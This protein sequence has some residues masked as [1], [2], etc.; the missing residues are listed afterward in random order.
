MVPQPLSEQQTG[1][2]WISLRFDDGTAMMGYLMRQTDAPPYS[3][4]T[5]IEPDGTA[6]ALPVG[7]LKAEPLER[8]EVAGREV[9]TTWRLAQPARGLD[10]E[11]RAL[12]PRA[13]NATAF[14]YWEGPVTVAGSHVGRGYLEM[15]GL[16]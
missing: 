12:H 10:I 11:V 15:T 14:E 8:T 16:D 3:V 13:W 6:T 1:W 2:D 5:W 7:A 9:P 4:A